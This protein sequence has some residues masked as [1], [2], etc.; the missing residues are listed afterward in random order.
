[1]TPR[2]PGFLGNGVEAPETASHPSLAAALPGGPRLLEADGVLPE[3]RIDTGWNPEGFAAPRRRGHA[4]TLLAAGLAVLLLG[5]LVLAGLGFVQ[6]RFRDGAALGWLT[7]GVL[8]GGLWLVLA[9]LWGE[10]RAWRRLRQVDALRRLLAR[11]DAALEQVQDGCRAWLGEI[12]AALPDGPAA[13]RAVECST[14]LP[15]LR[16]VLRRQVAEPL[17]QATRAAGRRAALQGGVLVAISPS[18]ALDGVLAGL[19]GLSLMRQVAALHGLRPNLAVTLAL[20]RRVVG[21]AAG[22]AGIDLLAQ[23]AVERLLTDTPGLRQLAA[24]LPGASATA[25]RLCRLADVTAA[26]CCPLEPEAG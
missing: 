4:P 8:G 17:R 24:I 20:L 7:V 18:P 3:G 9:G 6:A 26:A 2:G 14:S 22:T 13:I 16:A 25:L 12:G 10:W 21:T 1:M 19:R 23:V 11:P 5:W 15:Q